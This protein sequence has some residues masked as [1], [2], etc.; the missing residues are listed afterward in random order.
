MIGCNFRKIFC[1]TFNIEEHILRNTFL[2][3]GIFALLFLISISVHFLGILEFK[4]APAASA[5]SFVSD[6]SPAQQEILTSESSN[7]RDTQ[8]KDALLH[9]QN[10]E[11]TE[12][13]QSLRKAPQLLSLI[14]L[15]SFQQEVLDPVHLSDE[16]LCFSI[17]KDITISFRNL[18]I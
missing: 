6:V 16:A 18:R 9:R 10:A 13:R 7:S 4:T 3:T 12:V 11:I 17:A 8:F 14:F 5:V 2:A 1:V 15:L